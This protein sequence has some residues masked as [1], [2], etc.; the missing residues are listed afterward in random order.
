MVVDADLMVSTANSRAR[1]VLGK[2]SVEIE[3]RLGGEVIE[4]ANASLPGGCGGTEHCRA[5]TIRNSVMETMSS[6][7]S[8]KDVTAYKDIKTSQGTRR[9][10]FSISTERVRDLVLVKIKRH[11]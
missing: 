1:A 10:R 2:D 6:G 9:E 8:L 3:D 4:C 11:G 5:C 7:K